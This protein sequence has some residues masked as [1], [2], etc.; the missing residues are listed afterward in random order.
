MRGGQIR[1]IL[2]IWLGLVRQARGATC[3]IH[4]PSAISRDFASP[5]MSNRVAGQHCSH[6][7]TCRRTDP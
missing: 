6:P 1:L 3:S 4:K 2:A 7:S 5:Q